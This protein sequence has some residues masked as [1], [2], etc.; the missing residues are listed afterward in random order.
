MKSPVKKT[1]DWKSF[2]EAYPE[3]VINNWKI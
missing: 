3:R 2:I 1:K